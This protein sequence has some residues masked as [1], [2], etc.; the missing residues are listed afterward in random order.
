MESSYYRDNPN[1]IVVNTS[2]YGISEGW[3]TQITLPNGKYYYV[4]VGSIASSIAENKGFETKTVR[5]FGAC[6]YAN[7][8]DRVFDKFPIQIDDIDLRTII[9]K[10]ANKEDANK[11]LY[12][13]NYNFNYNVFKT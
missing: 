5:Y 3:A 8:N 12:N 7:I 11:Y 4:G 13:F 6:I 9:D 2:G 1:R 10:V